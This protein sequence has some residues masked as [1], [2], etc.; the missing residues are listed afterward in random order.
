MDVLAYLRRK[1]GDENMKKTNR[2]ILLN[3]THELRQFASKEKFNFASSTLQEAKK[4]AS[5]V[6][7]DL[8]ETYPGVNVTV[9]TIEQGK[10]QAVLSIHVP[11]TH[12]DIQE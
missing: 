9:S 5:D 6:E 12:I 3:L 11:L 2:E 8:K 4:L 1:Y 7:K 10:G